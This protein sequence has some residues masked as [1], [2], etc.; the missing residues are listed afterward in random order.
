MKGFYTIGVYGKK[1]SSYIL[2]ATQNEE[3]LVMLEQGVSLRDS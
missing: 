2:T 3:R 1:R